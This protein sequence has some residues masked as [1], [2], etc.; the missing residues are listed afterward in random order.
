MNLGGRLDS[1]DESYEWLSV[2]FKK[3]Q[4]DERSTFKN[5]FKTIINENSIGNRFNLFNDNVIKS[6][7]KLPAEISLRLCAIRET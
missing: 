6:E 5:I 2:F 7:K 1:I 4:S 3:K